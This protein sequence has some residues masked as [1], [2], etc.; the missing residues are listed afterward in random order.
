MKRTSAVVSWVLSAGVCSSWLL[1]AGACSSGDRITFGS[2]LSLTGTLATSGND[3]LQGMQ[4]AVDEINAQGGVLGRTVA[5]VNED[6]HSD[7]AGA[8]VAATRLVDDDHAVAVIGAIGSDSTLAIEKVTTPHQIVLIS[9]ASTSPALTGISPYFFRTCASDALQGQLLAKRAIAKTYTRVAVLYIPGA[10]GTGLAASFTT[11][12][13]ALGGTVTFSQM[14]E[15]QASYVD[16]LTQIFAT[17]PQA[18]LL[19]V[20]AVDAAQIIRDYNNAFLFEGAFW[21]FTDAGQDTSFVDGVGAR[22]FTFMHEGTANADPSGPAYATFADA[23]QRRFGHLPQGFAPNFYDAVYLVALAIQ[24]AGS[25]AGPA[26]RDQVR[27]IADP[28]GAVVGP[29]QWAQARAL[30]AQGLKINYEGASG[31]VD[32]DAQGDVIAPYDIWMIKD[33][34]ITTIEHSVLP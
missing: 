7:Q 25:S 23:Y 33:G 5:L 4:L 14:V 28:P 34:M 3:H 2:V 15:H 10:Y 20:Y 21:F 30:I 29:Q 24:R 22:N 19:V 16:L 27:A 18:I 11:S 32:V 17:S 26:M 31:S 8:S 1:A 9:G 12:F 13:T 6:D